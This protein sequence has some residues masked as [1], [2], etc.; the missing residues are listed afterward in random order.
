MGD[1][2]ATAKLLEMLY[3]HDQ[4]GH[5]QLMSKANNGIY[6]PPLIDNE[7]IQSLPEAT[8]IYFFHD[9]KGKIIYVG[10]AKSIR[11]RVRSHF[12]GKDGQKKQDLRRKIAR[13]SYEITG[14]EFVASLHE[15]AQIKKFFPEFNKAQKFPD[16]KFGIYKWVDQQGFERLSLSKVVRN[17]K[18]LASFTSIT[19]MRSLI[20]KASQEMQLCP[21]LCGMETK[22]GLCAM[23]KGNCPKICSEQSRAE[24]HNI[25]LNEFI[26]NKLYSNDNE[27]FID[28]GRR[29]DELSFVLF[30][31][32]EYVGFG[33]LEDT[34]FKADLALLEFHLIPQK[35]DT[36]IK[37]IL[38]FYRQIWPVKKRFLLTQ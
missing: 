3:E 21:R 5:W 1:A 10:K 33:Y 17:M 16:P 37:R 12:T 38:K 7:A 27:V 8:G 9:E 14:S 30:R 28:K 29:E 13:I 4:T 26:S 22:E 19:E 34:M 11:S 2:R 23:D 31:K 24:E 6:L 35:E 20:A 25:S 36:E 15:V 32:G 18:P